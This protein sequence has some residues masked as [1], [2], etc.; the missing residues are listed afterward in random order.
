LLAGALAG[1]HWANADVQCKL[2]LNQH[3]P[4][5]LD[6]MKVIYAAGNENERSLAQ[7]MGKLGLGSD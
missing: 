5:A 4:E 3:R 2:K 7:W 6:A 1:C